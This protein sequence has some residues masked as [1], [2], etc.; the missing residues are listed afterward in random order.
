M[1]VKEGR[2]TSPTLVNVPASAN[3]TSTSTEQSRERYNCVTR[4]KG[5]TMTRE[6][7]SREHLRMKLTAVACLTIFVLSPAGIAQTA[8][9]TRPA[10]VDANAP[11]P[12]PVFSNDAIQRAIKRGCEYLL[13]TQDA[14]GAWP[15]W[16]DAND[17]STAATALVGSALMS[18]EMLQTPDPH[19]SKTIHYLTKHPT[20]I[21]LDLGLRCC[22]WSLAARRVS[23]DCRR[24]LREDAVKLILGMDANG[25]YG[26]NCDPC[27][28]ANAPTDA[29]NGMYGMMGVLASATSDQEIPMW[30]W[31]RVRTHW[32][33]CQN[34]DGGWGSAKGL[35]SSAATTAGGLAALSTC[36]DNLDYDQYFNCKADPKRLVPINR[37][38]AWMDKN[39]QAALAGPEG[40]LAGSDGL[41]SL[42]R[43]LQFAGDAT[44]RKYLGGVD[45]YKLGA[46]ELL[47][48]QRPDGSWTGKNKPL[49]ETAHAILFLLSDQQPL[50]LNKLQYNGDWNNRPRDMAVLAWWLHRQFC[51]APSRDW[52][53]TPMNTPVEQWHDS[54]ALYIGGAKAPNF[55]DGDIEK[56]RNYVLQGGT[57]LS[58]RQCDGN[59]FGDGI[60]RAY[61]KMFPEYR[62]QPIKAGNRML[63]ITFKLR[64]RDGLFEITNGSRPL[65][66]HS[67]I[68]LSKSWQG[69]WTATAREDFQLAAN[70]LLYVT[71]MSL[72]GNYGCV[73]YGILPRPYTS[74][75][76]AAPPRKPATTI[77]L[78]RLKY[79]GNWDPEPLAW[80]RFGRL[81][82]A[83]RGIGV[84]A[85]ATEIEKLPACGAR[86]AHLTG[87]TA[88]ALSARQQA[89]IKKFIE[90]GGTLLIDAAGGSPKFRASAEKMLGT[91]FG[92]SAL[93][94]LTPGAAVY[95]LPG[96]KI[97]EFNYNR[98]AR[99]AGW[100]R[101]TPNL[102]GIKIGGRISV[103]LSDMDLTTALLGMSAYNRPG[104]KPKSAYN[105]VRNVLLHATSQPADKEPAN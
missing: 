42:L 7:T 69:R 84:D 78:A 80:V 32:L 98:A 34:A 37:A 79:D 47:R 76:L 36:A 24:P 63:T 82:T 35:A 75:W 62:M 23:T 74:P 87:T 61:A 38:L 68:D 59:G 60:R 65:V 31:S 100:R 88:I 4:T 16:S 40:K 105:I 49:I 89:A 27:S 2:D 1:Y 29:I 21:T 57:I 3:R 13:K 15:G 44:G 17:R 85:R 83:D 93:K 86:V 12:A 28:N 99:K 71:D 91:I 30:Y 5:I 10:A 46:A 94:G 70:I 92:P 11:A 48:R 52:H 103:V 14:N 66:I 18:A 101:K 90:G 8:S 53:I 58:V 19:I 55:T 20:H 51:G 97:E 39:L 26:Q 102:R 67:D 72:C 41:Y 104:Y 22:F 81:L 33:D 43:A 25:A 9:S 64:P 96:M 77:Q 73:Y 95:Y 56:L 6:K 54:P 45:W 50:A